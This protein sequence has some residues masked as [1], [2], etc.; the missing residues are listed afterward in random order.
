[1]RNNMEKKWWNNL[2]NDDQMWLMM[3]YG[4]DTPFNPNRVTNDQIIK[5][6]NL[7]HNIKDDKGCENKNSCC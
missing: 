4:F 5:L 1:M 6:Y 7:E 3:K 2:N